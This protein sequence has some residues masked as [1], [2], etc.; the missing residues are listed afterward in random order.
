MR[1]HGAEHVLRRM[2]A[3][4]CRRRLRTFQAASRV[5]IT[6]DG[7]VDAGAAGKQVENRHAVVC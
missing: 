5:H 7:E 4:E 3:A 6:D 2:L 1:D